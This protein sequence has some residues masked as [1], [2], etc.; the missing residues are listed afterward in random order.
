MD[1]NN[2]LYPTKFDIEDR[3]FSTLALHSAL[4]IDSSIINHEEGIDYFKNCSLKLSKILESEILR[5]QKIKENKLGYESSPLFLLRDTLYLHEITQNKANK[6]SLYRINSK[7]ATSGPYLKEPLST[8]ITIR[9][10][11]QDLREE[12]IPVYLRISNNLSTFKEE[13]KSQQESLRDFSLSLSKE[14][15]RCNLLFSRFSLVA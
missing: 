15:D 3:S 1:N 8:I 9:K 11:Y 12:I 6:I 7:L 5:L 14:L 4:E 10:T 13:C 2:W